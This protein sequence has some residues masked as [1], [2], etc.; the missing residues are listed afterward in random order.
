[1]YMSNFCITRLRS[2]RR[3]KF[4]Q[5]RYDNQPIELLFENCYI[6][7]GV[8]DNNKYVRLD[9]SKSSGDRQALLKIHEYIKNAVNPNFSPLKYA[10]ENKSWDDIVCK[11]SNAQ[12]EPFEKYLS[13]GDKVDVILTVGAF[14]SFGWCLNVKKLWCK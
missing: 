13:K 10:A 9:L 6:V 2:V 8:Y 4:S 3:G 7:R 1:M 5:L 12:W 14:G 11:I